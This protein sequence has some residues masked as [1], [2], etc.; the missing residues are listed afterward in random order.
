MILMEPE[1]L[2]ED[3]R[4][5]WELGQEGATMRAMQT[6]I[7]GT[8]EPCDFSQIP[9]SVRDRITEPQDIERYLKSQ[10]NTLGKGRIE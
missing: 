9:E 6:Q 4:T 5:P 8:R 1:I 7:Y 2:K 3:N 10:L